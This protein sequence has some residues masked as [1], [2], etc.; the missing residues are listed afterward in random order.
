MHNIRYEFKTCQEETQDQSGS[1][2]Q[3]KLRQFIFNLYTKIYNKVASQNQ[4]GLQV[5]VFSVGT[6]APPSKIPTHIIL[7]DISRLVTLR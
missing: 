6:K 2:K 4:L 7:Y 3:Q 1:L 5:K